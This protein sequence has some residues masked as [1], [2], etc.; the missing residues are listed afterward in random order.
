MPTLRA[1]AILVA[2]LA[3]TLP[4]MPLQA[5]LVALRS[6]YARQLPQHYHR[7]VC[8]LLGIRIRQQGKIA[9]G[10][11]VL[12]VANH[13]S[14]LDIPVLSSIAPVSFIAKREVAGWPFIGWLAKLQ[15]SVFIDRERRNGAREQADSIAGRLDAGENLVLF[16]EGTTGNGNRILPFKSTLVGA[17]KLSA[18]SPHHGAPVIQSLAIAYTRLHGLPLGRNLR[19]TIAWY[20][21]MDV[22][23]HAWA[24]LKAGPVDV[25]ICIGPPQQ[26][27]AALDRK[28]LTRRLQAE[29]RDS[30]NAALGGR[31]IAIDA[32]A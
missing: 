13:V 25:E 31:R 15:R 2:F 27:T 20:G 21:D 7:A 9:A 12:I 14:W 16:A 19:P 6:S 1:T 29:V 26:F 23:G 30:F 3:L 17:A 10:R 22:P 11:P 28:V 4:L 24:L 8:W 18:G 32:G 5:L